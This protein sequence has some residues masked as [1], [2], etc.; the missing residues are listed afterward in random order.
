M[1][2]RD[3]VSAI[4]KEYMLFDIF[5]NLDSDVFYF[6]YGNMLTIWELYLKKIYSIFECYYWVEIM[7][8]H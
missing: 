6:P 8:H 2:I 5:V 3:Q 7:N 1:T 4:L